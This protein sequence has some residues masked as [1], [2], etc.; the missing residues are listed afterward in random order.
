MEPYSLYLTTIIGYLKYW[1]SATC[2]TTYCRFLSNREEREEGGT[3]QLLADIKL[4][5]VVHLQQS[6]GASIL[7]NNQICY[8]LLT[9]NVV[10]ISS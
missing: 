5:L 6:I 2:L 10:I 1:L 3:P 7:N 4:G 8:Q 9:G